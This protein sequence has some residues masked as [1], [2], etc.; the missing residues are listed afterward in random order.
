MLMRVV[1]DV[2]AEIE[3][4]E[5]PIGVRGILQGEDPVSSLQNA[6]LSMLA[7]AQ[8]GVMEGADLAT[9]RSLL[10]GLASH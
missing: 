9:I 10:E 8:D 7:V 3:A 5:M 1:A 2:L 4:S 6:A